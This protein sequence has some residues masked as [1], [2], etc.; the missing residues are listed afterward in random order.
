MSLACCRF[1]QAVI[2]TCLN[3]LFKVGLLFQLD[4]H[5]VA[6]YQLNCW[7]LH[8]KSVKRVVSYRFIYIQIFI[9]IQNFLILF[10]IFSSSIEKFWQFCCAFVIFIEPFYKIILNHQFQLTITTLIQR[11]SQCNKQAIID[12]KL[13]ITWNI[14][15]KECSRFKV[16]FIDSIQPVFD[17]H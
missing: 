14:H 5:P 2:C 12:F 10:Y 9:Y 6:S 4:K 15:L 8:L 13:H 1:S 11:K 17:Y 16:N 3:H 7:R